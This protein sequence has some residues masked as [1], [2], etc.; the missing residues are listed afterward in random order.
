MRNET[1]NVIYMALDLLNSIN[2]TSHE[3]NF[4]KIDDVTYRE[5]KS[6]LFDLLN[7][8]RPNQD[9]L[10]DTVK[11]KRKAE[12]D[13]EKIS[14]IIGLL[15]YIL[16]DKKKFKTN[17]DI[18]KLAKDSLNMEIPSWK[19][20]SRNEM[21]GVLISMIASKPTEELDLFFEAWKEFTQD[22]INNEKRSTDSRDYVDVWLE[23][24]NK[25][26]R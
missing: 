13:S 5:V 18:A 25:Y 16:I 21:V 3:S 24:F 17:S 12:K 19:N 1:K 20:R 15:P 4:L 2:K 14:E 7:E 6:E 11:Q 8:N 26:K 23:F 9:K 22:D 10:S